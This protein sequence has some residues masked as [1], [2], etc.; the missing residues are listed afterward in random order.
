MAPEGRIDAGP[1]KADN[2]E[3]AT[4]RL[5]P[6]NVCF[7]E[8]R[9]SSVGTLPCRHHTCDSCL[10][11]C[12]LIRAYFASSSLCCRNLPTHSFPLNEGRTPCY[13]LLK[14]GCWV[15]PPMC[16][17]TSCAAHM[18]C[19]MVADFGMELPCLC[20]RASC[21]PAWTKGIWTGARAHCPIAG[22][23]YPI[24]PP[25]SCYVAGSWRGF[26]I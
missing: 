2:T 22:Q 14:E 8:T 6:C 16:T 13:A 23:S 5:Q 9:S 17:S 21:W 4:A 12:N 15:A 11:V 1:V 19:Q 7:E 26:S 20:H 18:H 24:R 25:S 10:K 3:S